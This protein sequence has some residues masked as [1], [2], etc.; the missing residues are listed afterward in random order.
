MI[1]AAL[2]ERRW[3]VDL[4]NSILDIGRRCFP[5]LL[6]KM[7]EALMTAYETIMVVLTIIIIIE[8]VRRK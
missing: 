1:I 4:S 2:L 7:K 8:S 5:I 6:K 3:T